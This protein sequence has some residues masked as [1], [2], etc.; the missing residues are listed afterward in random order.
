VSVIEG[1]VEMLGHPKKSLCT[2]LVEDHASFRQALA[3]VLGREP[4][5]EVVAQA[6]SLAEARQVLEGVDVAIV[7]LALP[8]GNGADL[9]DD[10]HRYNPGVVVLVLSATLDQKN[11]VSAVE[12]GA[13]GVLDK[14]A[15]LDEIVGA[16]RRLKAGQAIPQQQKVVRVLRLLGERGDR[17][18]EQL[19]AVGELTSREREVIQALAEGLDSEGVAEKL[20]ISIDEERSSVTSIFGKLGVRSRLQALAVASRQGIVEIP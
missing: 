1:R 8:D 17:E 6:G 5:F 19:T 7:D 18:R 10:L 16:V 20:G 14:L 13:A 4:G 15:D 11:L 9:I 2:M 12:T 3:F